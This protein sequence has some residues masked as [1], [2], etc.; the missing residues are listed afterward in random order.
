MLFHSFLES[1]F[2]AS[3]S[4]TSLVSP[5]DTIISSIHNGG[6]GISENLDEK[7]WRPDTC[8]ISADGNQPLSPNSASLFFLLF[9][10][11]FLVDLLLACLKVAYGILSH[12]W[13]CWPPTQQH[14]SISPSLT[15]S[16]WALQRLFSPLPLSHDTVHSPILPHSISH[17]HT[18]V[19][20]AAEMAQVWQLV[21]GGQSRLKG[22]VIS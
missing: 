20:F 10:F 19:K 3:L 5:S 9:F 4:A 16:L 21:R 14:A 2:P 13:T 6:R 7:M 1:P 15:A 18:S 17:R 12:C 22:T 11:T 8:Y